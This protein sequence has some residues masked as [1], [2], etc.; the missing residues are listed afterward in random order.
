VEATFLPAAILPELFC[1]SQSEK[2][3]VLDRI[4]FV[5]LSFVLS[6]LKRI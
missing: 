5:A 3:Y 2:N 1:Y 4:V 6:V